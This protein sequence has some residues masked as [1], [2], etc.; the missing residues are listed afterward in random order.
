MRSPSRLRH[1]RSRGNRAM[2]NR[3]PAH[4]VH[5]VEALVTEFLQHLREAGVD[6]NALAQD[7]AATLSATGDVIVVPVDPASLP[8]Q[9]S[10][11]ACYDARSDPPRLLVAQDLS[12]GRRAFST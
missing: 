10:V 7:P 6:L 5:L 9:C 2:T 1:H 8:T 11:A 12:A 3:L 4:I